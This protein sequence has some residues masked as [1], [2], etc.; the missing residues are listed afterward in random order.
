MQLPFTT[1]DVFTSTRL[2][3]N[4]LAVVQVP[5]DLRPHLTQ[6]LKQKIAR[7]F[8]L[9]ETVFLHE[10]ASTAGSNAR[11][12]DIFTIEEE[13]PL[14]GHPTVGTAVLVQYHLSG[15]ETI[16][17]LIT[18]AGP[19]GI[20]PVSSTSS[21]SKEIRAKIPHNVHLHGKTLRDVVPADSG[22]LHPNPE[23]RA[24]ELAAPVLSIVKGMTFV[25]VPLPS[26]DLLSEVKAMRLD[27]NA[28]ETPLLDDGWRDSFVARYYYVDVGCDGEDNNDVRCIRTRMVELGFEDPATGSAASALASYLTLFKEQRGR[29]F[30]VTQGVEMGRKSVIRVDTTVAGEDQE[31]SSNLKLEGLW[32]GGTAVL[33]MQ[34]T[35]QVD[36]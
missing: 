15:T 24:A 30:Q 36:T 23:I 5:K 26:L 25:L 19:V 21:I 2:E 17:S 32:L 22:N 4:P 7:E 3:G 16:R 27:F 12:I 6:P 8:N 10:G 31:G 11:E 29:R 33:V 1:L 13:L 14:A 34:G 18:K 35:I 28:L 9:S 20:E